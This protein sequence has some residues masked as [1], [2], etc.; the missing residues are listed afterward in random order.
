MQATRL[1]IVLLMSFILSATASA[2]VFESGPSDPA[3]FTNVINLPGAV[4]PDGN[5]VGGVD[6]EASHNC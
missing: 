1:M 6:G 4:L 3:L 5:R 2:Q